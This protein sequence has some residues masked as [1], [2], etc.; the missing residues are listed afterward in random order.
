MR[1]LSFLVLFFIVG[2]L[3]QP[4]VVFSENTKKSEVD[5]LNDQIAAKKKKIEEIQKSIDAYKSKINETQI[6]T[7]SLKNQVNLLDNHITQVNLDVQA[8]EEKLDTLGLQ[9]KG[10]ELSIAEKN[11]IIERQKRILSELIR[12]LRRE[13][14][15]KMIEIMAAYSSLSDFYDRVNRVQKLE[16]DL[17]KTTKTIRLAKAELET[18]HEATVETKQDYE[19]THTE[20]ESKKSNLQNQINHKQ[21]LLSETQASE[22]KYKTLVSSLKTQYQQTENEIAGIESQVRKK[23]AEQQK[24]KPEKFDVDSGELSWPVSSRRVTAYF[25]DV[26]Y[27]YRQ[28]FEHNAIDIVA[29]HGTAV[30]AAA[31]G[32]VARAKQCTTASCYSYIMLVHSNGVSTVYGHLSA[33]KA[34]EEQFVTRGDI[35]GYSGATPG[36]V[37]AG[38]FT[39]GPHLHF[40]V[41]KN[42]I[43]VNPLGYLK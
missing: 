30:R 29:S 1:K 33:L 43:P 2:S 21:D 7:I 36:T 18:K 27:P 31:S 9:L 16:Y 6:K 11:I 39:T 28:V 14:G 20:L 42:G 24:K 25:H 22:Q 10:L 17:G 37:G 4:V 3:T 41:R 34:D 23:L 19:E 15:K 5:I 13:D 35:I 26:S 38:P 12:E 40:E 8:T 32:Y